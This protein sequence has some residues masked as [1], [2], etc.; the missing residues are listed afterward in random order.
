MQKITSFLWFETEAEEAANFYVSVFKNSK[1]TRI[2]RVGDA[3]PG[4]KGSVLV[5]DFEIEGVPFSAL[6][7]N[8]HFTLDETISFVIHCDSQEEVDHYWSKLTAGGKEIQCGWLKDKFGVRWQVTP[9]VL[10][11]LIGDPDP[12]KSA[13]VMQAMMKMVKIDIAKLEAAARGE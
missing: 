5:A 8:P 12:A 6:N 1:I 11:K 2:V 13:R 7:G 3:G 4:P 9:K 10:L